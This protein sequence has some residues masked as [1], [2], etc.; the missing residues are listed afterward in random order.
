MM[1]VPKA[2]QELVDSLHRA[3]AKIEALR[4]ALIAYGRHNEGCSGLFGPRYP[5]RC[6]WRDTAAS[7]GVREG[8]PPE[9]PTK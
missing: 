8:W 5:C 6:G 7:L 9:A 2:T 4:E 1:A 3:G